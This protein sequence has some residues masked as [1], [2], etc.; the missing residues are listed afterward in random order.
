MSRID[1]REF[2]RSQG[3]LSGRL[4]AHDAPRL[5]EL[6]WRVNVVDFTIRGR[7]DGH[8]RLYLDLE[9]AGTLTTTC[10]RCLQPLEQALRIARAL[11]L[12]ASMAAIEA[13]DDDV[14]RVLASAAMEVGTLVEDELIL[15]LPMVG[16][17]EVC[18]AVRLGEER[19]SPSE[20]EQTERNPLMNAL[21]EWTRK[22][23]TS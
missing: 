16:R 6:G 17:H 10:Q 9:A 3:R 20:G 14:D 21:R 11:Q 23:R 18:E 13:A 5:E 4:L 7:G 1:G 2:A 22:D 12:A 15:E 8:G 19:G